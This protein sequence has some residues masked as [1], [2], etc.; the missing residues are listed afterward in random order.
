[1]DKGE[2]AATVQ[3]LNKVF[4]ST[5]VVVITHYSGLSVKEISDFRRKIKAAGGRSK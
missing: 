3:S 5:N 4:A 2:K 1:M